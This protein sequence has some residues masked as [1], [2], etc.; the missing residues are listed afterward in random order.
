[1][2]VLKNSKG[3]CIKLL[4]ISKGVGIGYQQGCMYWVSARVYVL[5]ISKGVC[6]GYQQG[7]MY[8]ISARVYV[9]SC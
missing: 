4:K 2:Y 7:C 3:V 9:L 8:W 6:T 5:D 1:M